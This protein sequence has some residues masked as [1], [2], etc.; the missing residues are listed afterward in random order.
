MNIAA[1]YEH[2][3]CDHDLT[4]KVVKFYLTTTTTGEN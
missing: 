4:S 1:K 3:T 2:K